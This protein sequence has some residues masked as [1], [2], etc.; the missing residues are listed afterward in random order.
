MSSMMSLRR[1]MVGV[2]VF[3]AVSGVHEAAWAEQAVK[4]NKHLVTVRAP[5]QNGQVEILGEPG[6]IR[7]AEAVT[8]RIHNLATGQRS[9][10]QVYEDGGFNGLIAAEPGQRVR[11]VAVNVNKKGKSQGTFTVPSPATMQITARSVAEP[12]A[13]GAEQTT[14]SEPALRSENTLQGE[15]AQ[16]RRALPVVAS[17]RQMAVV[18][19]VIDTVSGEILASECIAGSPKTAARHPSKYR[20]IADNIVRRCALAIRSQLAQTARKDRMRMHRRPDRRVPAQRN[21]ASE[22]AIEDSDADGQT[23]QAPK[24]SGLEESHGSGAMP[25]SPSDPNR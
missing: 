4:V 21:L 1:I 15:P 20:Q 8:V 7:S 19:T 24:S 16:G 2:F 23:D 11:V 13:A 17:I 14:Q 12:I 18:V 22:A 9:N 25:E 6:A 3:T 10:V 5:D